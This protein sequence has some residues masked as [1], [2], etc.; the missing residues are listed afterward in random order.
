METKEQ[1]EE[2]LRAVTDKYKYKRRQIRDLEE[3][4]QV[5]F[6]VICKCAKMCVCMC[7]WECIW[8]CVYVCVCEQK[9]F[10]FPS[11]GGCIREIG[12]GGMGEVIKLV[13]RGEPIITRYN[14][15][16]Y[17][18]TALVADDYAIN[19][20]VLGKKLQKNTMRLFMYMQ[21]TLYFIY[22]LTLK[23]LY[24]QWDRLRHVLRT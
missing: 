24:L 20:S 2:Q 21:M 11:L 17:P 15:Q 5:H 13:C 6:W 1:L 18:W 22:L 19:H 4:L 14:Y 3:E 9:Y 23:I 10:V 16:G 7:V 12:K 8:V